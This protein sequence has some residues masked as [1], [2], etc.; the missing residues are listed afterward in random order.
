MRLKGEVALVTGGASGLGRAI[1][2]RYVAEGARVAVLDRSSAGLAKLKEAHGDAVVGIEGDVRFLDSHKQAVARCVEAFGKL[3]CLVGNAG[4]WDYM[5][6]L[7]DIPD[8]RIEAAFDEMFS[9]NV[10]GYLL[11]AKAALPA[12]FQSK[13]RVILTASNAAFYTSGGGPLYTACKHAVVGLI[14]QLAYEWGPYI[15]VNGIAPGGVVGADLRGLEALGLQ[16]RSISTISLPDMLNH[17]LPT[18]EVATAEQYAGAYVF[19][20]T[21]AETVPLT[22]SILDF[23]SGWG[24]GG[25]IDAN[26]GAELEKH[27]GEQAVRREPA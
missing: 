17:V 19:F 21:R 25:L 11:A 3:D 16:D 10:K 7:V 8:D 4:V 2:D 13:G 23:N 14:K 15:R 24:V 1:V 26:L 5:T 20:A 12:L 9:I 6:Q 18:G 22:G 27:F